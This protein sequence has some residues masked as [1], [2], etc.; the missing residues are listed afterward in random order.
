MRFTV[1][2]NKQKFLPAAK[3]KKFFTG[4]KNFIYFE[5]LLQNDQYEHVGSF[6]QIAFV[7]EEV[8]RLLWTFSSGG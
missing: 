3:G 8:S 2:P 5:I 6:S 7:Q 4:N 1:I